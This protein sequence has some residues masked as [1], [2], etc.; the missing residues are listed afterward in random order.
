MA[1]HSSI[2]AWRIPWREE[3][4]R[5]QSTGSQRVGHDWA[6]SLHYCLWKSNNII[7][8]SIAK[9]FQWLTCMWYSL[10]QS[11]NSVNFLPFFLPSSPFFPACF[12]LFLFLPFF[13]FLTLSLILSSI[14]P[15]PRLFSGKGMETYNTPR[16]IVTW[17][18]K[19]SFML[20]HIIFITRWNKI[21]I[22]IRINLEGKGSLSNRHTVWG[23][24]LEDGGAVG[25]PNGEGGFVA[26]GGFRAHSTLGFHQPGVIPK[27]RGK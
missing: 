26:D 23:K 6:T 22:Y 19:S 3:P 24:D 5:L 21:K 17:T 13:F 20:S 4:G 12:V 7:R 14:S 18:S 9:S 27:V 11:Q 15:N 16:G 10:P 1:T 25:A 2:L 8:I